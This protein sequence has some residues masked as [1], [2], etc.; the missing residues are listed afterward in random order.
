MW[1]NGGVGGR[2]I[3]QKL[4]LPPPFLIPD[5]KN[6]N[7]RLQVCNG[8]IEAIPSCPSYGQYPFLWV[9]LKYGMKNGIKRIKYMLLLGKKAV[10][11]STF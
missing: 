3:Y 4:R 10:K 1:K 2:K 6:S 7:K 5:I 8:S 9:L 11:T